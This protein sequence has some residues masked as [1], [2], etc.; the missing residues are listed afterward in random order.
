M[1]YTLLVVSFITLFLVWCVKTNPSEPIPTPATGNEAPMPTPIPTTTP[2]LTQSIEALGTEPFWNFTVI[3]NNLIWNQ[4]N[5]D[6]SIWS[7]QYTVTTTSS[8][9]TILLNGTN[10]QATITAQTCS[11]GMSDNSYSH[12]VN[13]VVWTW[14]TPYNGCATIQ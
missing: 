9:S 11:D 12:T 2:P 7:T 14:N 4:P 1:K 5:D 10:I 13:I 3:W 8:W 6:W